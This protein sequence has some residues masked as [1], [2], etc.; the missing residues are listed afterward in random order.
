MTTY[1]K[2]I[3]KFVKQTLCFVFFVTLLQ[4][5]H[6]QVTIAL[7]IDYLSQLLLLDHCH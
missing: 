2:R 7:H 6:T 4:D 1:I 3:Q 5:I